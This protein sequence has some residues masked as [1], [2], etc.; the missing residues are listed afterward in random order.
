MT[1]P[2]SGKVV[3]DD[4]DICDELSRMSMMDDTVGFKSVRFDEQINKSGVVKVFR[5]KTVLPH[6]MACWKDA[7]LV[8]R[9]SLRI[10]THHM[11]SCN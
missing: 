9:I 7:N 2:P 6:V 11:E 8:K 5:P 1:S 10:Q 3:L 4:D